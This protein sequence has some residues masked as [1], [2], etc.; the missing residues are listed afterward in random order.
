MWRFS[1]E[2]LFNNVN[3]ALLS[4]GTGMLNPAL[5]HIGAEAVSLTFVTGTLSRIGS[6]LAL[7]L[8]RTPVPASEGPWDTHLYRARISAQL[9]ASFISGA[10]L[11]GMVMSVARSF[12]LLPGILIMLV[13]ALAE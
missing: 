10:V 2:D 13:L 11:S 12:V 6:H 3:I 9:W 7:A 1:H 5:S 8:G 4:F